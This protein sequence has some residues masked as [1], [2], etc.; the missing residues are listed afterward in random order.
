LTNTAKDQIQMRIAMKNSYDEI[1]ESLALSSNTRTDQVKNWMEAL[2]PHYTLTKYRDGDVMRVKR[3]QTMYFE[4]KGSEAFAPM[5]ELI[6]ELNSMQAVED[7]QE[8]QQLDSLSVD[9]Y[10]AKH[11]VVVDGNSYKSF[12]QVQNDFEAWIGKQK[13]DQAAS[14]GD[15]IYLNA[16]APR[17]LDT[18]HPI[19]VCPE[20]G[21]NILLITSSEQACSA[22]VVYSCILSFKLQEGKTTV[23]AHSR[24]RIFGTY[25]S[26][27]NGCGAL[28][29]LQ[30][31]IDKLHGIRMDIEAG[32]NT[33]ELIAFIGAERIL[34]EFDFYEKGN[35]VGAPSFT[36]KRDSLQG[37]QFMT[38]EESKKR[39]SLRELMRQ[40]GAAKTTD[41]QP[42][43]NVADALKPSESASTNESVRRERDDEQTKEVDPR[44]DFD[45]ILKN[46]SRHGK[47]LLL[48]FSSVA[49][50]SQCKIRLDML[51]HRAS[52]AVS[53][54]DSQR[55]FS[56]RAAASSLPE[57]VCLYSDTLR[58]FSF[59]PYIH[60]GITWEDWSID[61]SGNAVSYS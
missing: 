26:T 30:E 50:L 58:G 54:E 49:A 52:F 8:G 22:S 44:A 47:H 55:L 13:S 18:V 43:Q 24:D 15:E 31:I 57:H 59:R 56:K 36:K 38:E 9:S 1:N 10:A 25:R 2:P 42:E 14:F 28:S 46:G 7:V 51:R 21:E 35:V 32:D 45:F 41:K 29:N 34:T 3:L 6:E 37:I 11:P 60:E 5:K 53:P 40:G 23:L 48:V 39:P 19:N 27:W 61:E 20:L 17:L 12:K 33:D 4:G 16:G